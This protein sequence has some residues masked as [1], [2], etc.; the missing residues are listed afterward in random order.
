MKPL[1]PR[2]ESI[3]NYIEMIDINRIYSNHGPLLIELENRYANFFGVTKS[4]VVCSANATLALLGA[5]NL[6]DSE[7]ITV[8]SFTFPAT[9]QAAI[10]S[11]KKI[12]MKDID[13]NSWMLPE[14]KMS[15]ETRIVVL[16]FGAKGQFELGSTKAVLRIIDAAA[17][18]GNFEG[19]LNK[20]EENEVMIFSLHA[21]KVLGI[22]EGAISI[23]GSNVIAAQFR[24]WINFGFS[25]TRNSTHLGINSKMSEMSAAYGLATLD[26][27]QNEKADWLHVN[28]M[29]REIEKKLSIS[30]Y[31]S[32]PEN[33]SPYWTVEFANESLRDLAAK[34][35]QLSGIDSRLWWEKGTHHMPAFKKFAIDAFPN[36]DAVAGRILGLPKYRD[37]TKADLELI[38]EILQTTI[39]EQEA[40]FQKPL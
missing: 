5:C 18:I 15:N 1:L 35:L 14:D 7:S 36:T 17:S 16:P 21:T 22:G 10:A 23:F 8:P 13:S 9:I 20:I 31:F 12:V 29:Q 4:Q 37:L 27:W 2:Y 3:R 39:L 32:K 26:G 6:T 34:K 19:K 28:L 40:N 11:H 25:G 30:P 24:S 33:V 38:N